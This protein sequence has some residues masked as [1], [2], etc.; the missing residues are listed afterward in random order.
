M[1]PWLDLKNFKLKIYLELGDIEL[2]KNIKEIIQEF[3]F[4]E[5]SSVS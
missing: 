5:V 3:D 4:W 1:L 2:T